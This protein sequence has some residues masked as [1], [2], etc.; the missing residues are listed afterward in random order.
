MYRVCEKKFSDYKLWTPVT[1]E[2]YS[3]VMGVFNYY[4]CS[5]KC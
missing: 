4:S 3:F 5:G 1:V 2:G